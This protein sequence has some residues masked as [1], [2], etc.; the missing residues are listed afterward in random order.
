MDET[1]WVLSKEGVLARRGKKQDVETKKRT[2]PLL[3]TLTEEL[4]PKWAEPKRGPSSVL[5]C[6]EYCAV[7]GRQLTM[8]S[9]GTSR[10]QSH[11]CGPDRPIQSFGIEFRLD[12]RAL[13][14]WAALVG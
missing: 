5:A 14:A 13:C 2:S 11:A 12:K 7:N 4:A 10:H 8:C 6:T 9:A 3:I 1:Y